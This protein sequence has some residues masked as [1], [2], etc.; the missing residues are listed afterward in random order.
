MPGR[1]LAL[2]LVVARSAIAGMPHV[3]HP[4]D[5]ELTLLGNAGASSTKRQMALTSRIRS[6]RLRS[7]PVPSA[8][9]STRA[10]I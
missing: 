10:R 6:T 5:A 4:I 9:P 3:P 8:G 1:P 2:L 7:P